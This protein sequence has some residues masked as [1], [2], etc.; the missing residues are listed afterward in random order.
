[1]KRFLAACG[2]CVCVGAVA[3]AQMPKYGVKVMQEKGVDY[4]KFKTYT[5]TQGQPSQDKKI[6]AAIVSAVDREMAGLGMTKAASGTGD[7]FVTYYSLSR[8]DVNLKAKPDAQGSLPHYSV[9][10]LVVGLLDTGTRKRLLRLRVDK[11]IETEQAKLEATINEAVA[12]L[13]AQYPTRTKK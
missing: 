9:G 3:F 7:V 4:A 2:L 5:W 10:T 1:M 12:A 6:D 8:T 11:P 13:Y